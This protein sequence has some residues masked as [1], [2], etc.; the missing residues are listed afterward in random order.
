MLHER[1]AE[2]CVLTDWDRVPAKRW[3]STPVQSVPTVNYLGDKKIECY[4][5]NV[6][7][8]WPSWLGKLLVCLCSNRHTDFRLCFSNDLVHAL[9][10]SQIL[11]WS[12]NM[13][14]CLLSVG[15][16]G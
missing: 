16:V 10:F 13:A 6:W 5:L 9:S 7:W 11:R 1:L 15:A 8:C 12:L 14:R 4:E 2:N 3:H